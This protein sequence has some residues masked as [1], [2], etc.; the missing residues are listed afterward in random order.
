MNSRI[1]EER[2]GFVGSCH[3]HYFLVDIML[4]CSSSSSSRK[5]AAR[6]SSQQ[7]QEEEV[8]SEQWRA[9]VG[10]CIFGSIYFL[11]F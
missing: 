7:Q 10:K 11:F 1:G 6:A 2:D 8:F 5:Q 9:F 3:G 4:E